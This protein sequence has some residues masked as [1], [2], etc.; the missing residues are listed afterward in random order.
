MDEDAS[1]A[2]TA[3]AVLAM[4]AKEQDRMRSNIEAQ[5]QEVVAEVADM[6]FNDLVAELA[7]LLAN[8]D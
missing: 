5:E 7:E 8:M 6:L 4:E 3:V 2:V 1:A